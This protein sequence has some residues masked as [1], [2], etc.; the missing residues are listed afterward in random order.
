MQYSTKLSVGLD[1]EAA[2][3]IQLKPMA[4]TLVPSTMNGEDMR[5]DVAAGD[6]FFA[7]VLP[8]SGMSIKQQVVAVTGTID[9]DYKGN[10]GVMLMNFTPSIVQVNKGDRI[11]QL[12]YHVNYARQIGAEVKDVERGADGFGSSGK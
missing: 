9:P 1:L 10:I 5:P 8:R 4:I 7:H 12:V 6:R 2:S 3:D 11:A